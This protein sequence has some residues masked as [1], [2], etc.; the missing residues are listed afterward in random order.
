M[1]VEEEIPLSAPDDLIAGRYRLVSLVGTGGMG[2]VWEAWDERLERPVALKQLH[3]QVGLSPADAELVNQRAMREARITARLHHRHA[4]PV[5]DVVEHDGQPCLIMQFLPSKPLSAILRERKFLPL[6]EAARICAQ[7][8]SAL[9]AAHQVGIV[10]RDVKPGNVLISDD[11]NAMISDFGISHAMGDATLTATGIMHGTPA[12]LAPEVALGAESDFASDVYA[13]GATLYTMLEGAPPFG[14]DQNYIALL[15]RVASGN[16]DPPKRSGA[17]T[18][19]M[20]GML[21]TDP[22]NRPSMRDAADTFAGWTAGQEF[23]LD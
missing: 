5:F 8:A 9:S 10:H 1:S 13:L 11:G 2:A 19:V 3:R 17:L 4:V 20:L 7:V 18:P 23:D 22:A 15:H 6:E 21:A 16:M 14:T 12:Y